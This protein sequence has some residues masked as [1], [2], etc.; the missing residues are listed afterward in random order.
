MKSPTRQFHLQR[1]AFDDIDVRRHGC[2][3]RRNQ[4]PINFD[5]NNTAGGG[6]ELGS[7]RSSAR[8]NLQDGVFRVDMGELNDPA[9]DRSI[10]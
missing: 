4:I 10:G 9:K 1:I 3:Q 6:R 8:T 5:G 7:E 2:P